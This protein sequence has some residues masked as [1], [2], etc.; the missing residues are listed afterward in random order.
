MPFP[1]SGSTG[2]PVAERV[3]R[4]GHV[5]DGGRPSIGGVRMASHFLGTG[6]ADR[7]TVALDAVA[8]SEPGWAVPTP[9]RIRRM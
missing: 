2:S 4:R 6:T 1:W 5:L 9:V 3:S 8:W 7:S